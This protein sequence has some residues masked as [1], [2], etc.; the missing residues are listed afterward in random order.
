[1]QLATFYYTVLPHI[2]TGCD[3]QSQ[4]VFK[5]N[6]KNPYMQKLRVQSQRKMRVSL[7]AVA[8]GIASSGETAEWVVAQARDNW[9]KEQVVHLPK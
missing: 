6:K 3:V 7:F 4:G 1:M 5:V 8:G 9:G 2:V